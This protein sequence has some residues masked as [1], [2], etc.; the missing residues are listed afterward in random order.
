VRWLVFVLA[1][2]FAGVAGSLFAINYE[3]VGL[4]LLSIEQSSI[5]LFAVVIGGL[6]SLP[7]AVAGAVVLTLLSTTLSDVT[8]AW[9]LYLGLAFTGVVLFARE[10]LA[11]A[12]AAHQPLWSRSAGLPA[13]LAR[14]YA[15]A[16]GAVIATIACGIALG[17]VLF[18]SSSVGS[19]SPFGLGLPVL[20]AAGLWLILGAGALAAALWATRRAA[21]GYREAIRQAGLVAGGAVD[22]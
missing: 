12:I 8:P 11:G 15:A 4:S 20:F 14:T 13:G 1:G 3:H 7:G 9:L 17:E 6:G 22:G 5:P 10:G 21:Q 2:G 19:T 18:A 16:A